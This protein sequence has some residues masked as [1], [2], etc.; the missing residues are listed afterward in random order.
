MF[1]DAATGVVPV[2]T[3]AVVFVAPSIT[4]TLLLL[5]LVTYI[6][7]VTGFTATELGPDP[8]GTVA[9]TVCA[10]VAVPHVM[11]RITSAR[12]AIRCI[13]IPLTRLRPAGLSRKLDLCLLS[14]QANGKKFDQN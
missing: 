13:L 11:D 5:G 9:V 4:V 6:L 14:M 8:T 7:F 12:L 2:A 1:T 3:V 10:F